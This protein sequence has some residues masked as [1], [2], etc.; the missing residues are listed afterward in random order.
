MKR[1]DRYLRLTVIDTQV[2]T[3]KP[4]WPPWVPI[5]TLVRFCHYFV[6]KLFFDIFYDFAMLFLIFLR[7]NMLFSETQMF[8]FNQVCMLR[9]FKLM[10]INHFFFFTIFCLHVL[11]GDVS[12]CK[13]GLIE[14]SK[15]QTSVSLETDLLQVGWVPN[16]FPSNLLTQNLNIVGKTYQ[17]VFGSSI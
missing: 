1:C 4:I 17:P 8:D 7:Y 9:H 10:L 5:G 6:Q 13:C 15:L 16:T 12:Q 14:S 3:L 11:C 2:L